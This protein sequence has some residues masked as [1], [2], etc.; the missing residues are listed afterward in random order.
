MNEIK[1]QY[2]VRP[3]EPEPVARFRERVLELLVPELLDRAPRRLTLHLS[4]DPPR[5]SV[6]P[7]RR[8]PLALVSIWQEPGATGDWFLPL[9]RLGRVSG[10]RVVESVPR[11]YERDWPEGAPTPGVG[12][13]TLFSRRPG[14]DQE[15]FLR[16]WHGGHTPLSLE[17][18]PIWRY[19]RNLVESVILEGSPPHDGIV[20]EHFRQREDLLSPPRFFGGA[21]RMLPNMLRVALDIRRFIHLP[22]LESYLVSEHR[23][24][25]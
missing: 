21:A 9:S 6:I 1:L 20:E 14:Q 4:L 15:A 8:R 23:L 10:Y 7:L 5:L 25:G 24:R 19:E 18:H 11:D 2:I 17:I 16:A 13:L 12:L 22:G 3:A